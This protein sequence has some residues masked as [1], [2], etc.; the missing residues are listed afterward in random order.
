M[1][2]QI[3]YRIRVKV[4]DIKRKREEERKRRKEEEKRK[5]STKPYV[6]INTVWFSLNATFH[7]NAT[8]LRHRSSLTAHHSPLIIH[9]SPIHRHTYKLSFESF[10]CKTLIYIATYP[11]CIQLF[12]LAFVTFFV[13]KHADY[14]QVIH[15][16]HCKSMNQ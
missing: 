13:T 12:H 8:Y 16:F 3:K 2:A 10:A 5:S 9:H 6:M 7:Q 4:I 14:L 15:I 11:V 1:H